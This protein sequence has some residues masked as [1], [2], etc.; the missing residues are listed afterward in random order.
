MPVYF[1]IA[2]R[3]ANAVHAARV[4][5]RRFTLPVNTARRHGT[6]REHG[7]VPSQ[8]HAGI[9]SKRLHISSVLNVAETSDGPS[10]AVAPN[11]DDV[12]KI[13]DFRPGYRYIYCT[14]EGNSN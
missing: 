3:H 11:T 13:G 2:R 12:G 5:G 10:V 14:S 8:T 7:C 6:A 9:A 4:D 1:F